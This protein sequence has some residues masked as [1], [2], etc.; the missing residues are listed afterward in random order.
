[1]NMKR[2]SVGTIILLI[3]ISSLSAG[4]MKSHEKEKVVA[5]VKEYN[6]ALM[7]AYETRN[8]DE[9]KNLTS[10]REYQKVSVYIMSY[11]GQGEKL[12]ARLMNLNVS[13]VDIAGNAADVTTSEEWEY[14]R[15][16]LK[17]GKPLIPKAKYS[18][19]TE[20]HLIKEGGKWKIDALKI[21]TEERH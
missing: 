18:Y 19:R 10:D 3:G 16:Y 2:T 21:I 8:F 17:T 1:M 4:C 20:Y 15:S 12:Y 6:K 9:L 11:A 13:K 5:L 7:K 14:Q